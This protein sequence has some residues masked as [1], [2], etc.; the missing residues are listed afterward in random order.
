MPEVVK[1][2]KIEISRESGGLDRLLPRCAARAR[3]R[4]SPGSIRERTG[5]DFV[6][7]QEVPELLATGRVHLDGDR[8]GTRAGT[9]PLGP[10]RHRLPQYD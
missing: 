5:I 2:E 3:R 8:I 10:L 1:A 9:R 7:E 4:W 6:L